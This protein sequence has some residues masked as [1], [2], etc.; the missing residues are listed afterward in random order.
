MN[1]S[2]R[3]G[4]DLDSLTPGPSAFCR[5]M[6]FLCLDRATF[7]RLILDFGEPTAGPK[8]VEFRRSR[9]DE[10][11]AHLDQARAYDAQARAYGHRLP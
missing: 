11:R 10:A 8:N 4:I 3:R 1:A 5:G 6:A 2:T 7:E 9:F